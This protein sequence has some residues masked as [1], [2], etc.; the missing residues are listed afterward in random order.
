MLLPSL[1]HRLKS[2]FPSIRTKF[3]F[4]IC[5]QSVVHEAWPQQIGSTILGFFKI[6]FLFNINKLPSRKIPSQSLWRTRK[7]QSLQSYPYYR[8]GIDHISSLAPS[9]S[10]LPFLIF[11]QYGLDFITRWTEARAHQPY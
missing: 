4:Y 1:T 6:P 3:H 10:F 5:C 9:S 11:V 7:L 8:R 2:Y